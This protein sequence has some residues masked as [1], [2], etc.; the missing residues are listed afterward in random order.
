MFTKQKKR[1]LFII[2]FCMAAVFLLPV[3][4]QDLLKEILPNGN[5]VYIC[6]IV[7]IMSLI[8]GLVFLILYL[9]DKP[10]QKY[11]ATA[12]EKFDVAQFGDGNRTDYDNFVDWWADCNVN[13]IKDN[14]LL[15]GAYQ[16]M[17][18]YNEVA[19]GGFGQFWD[20]AENENWDFARTQKLFKWLLPKE[21]FD[22]FSQALI[23][24]VNGED[25]E[26]FNK[27]FD[28]NLME[29]NV[30]PRLAERVANNYK[31]KVSLTQYDLIE[32]ITPYLKQ[33][34]YKKQNKRWKKNI[35]EF[36][37]T[38]YIQGSAYD[39]DSYYI[40]PGISL[41]GFTDYAPGAYGHF[42]SLDFKQ[43]SLA[44]VIADWEN[45][46]KEWTDKKLIKERLQKFLLWEERNPLEKRRQLA[47]QSFND[48]T[49]SDLYKD[50][51][52]PDGGNVFFS[53][54]KSL[55]EY[56]LQNF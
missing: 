28:F 36:T 30:L 44:Q 53:V 37:L 42:H 13:E 51:P 19:N 50:D 7:V 38:F 32:G 20:Y 6:V 22:L 5:L 48:G 46:V 31:Y 45:I 23:S 11:K 17:C 34:G 26:R 25:C 15:L 56:I 54:G 18:F 43:Q 27:A 12:A 2:F 4:M 33:Q 8:A 3:I 49:K 1:A 47:A 16:A 40:R 24:H 29:Q 10:K 21:I 9:R 14:S 55:R 35:G 41:N 39:T 52:L